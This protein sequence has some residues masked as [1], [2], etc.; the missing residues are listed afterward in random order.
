MYDKLLYLKYNNIVKKTKK[1]GMKN[2]K[3]K[4]HSNYQML[5]KRRKNGKR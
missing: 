2:G 1:G 4:R 3:H 5:L